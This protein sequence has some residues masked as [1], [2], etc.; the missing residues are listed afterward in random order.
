MTRPVILLLVLTTTSVPLLGQAQAPKDE[1]GAYLAPFDT[2]GNRIEL[3]VANSTGKTYENVEVRAI[4]TPAW[5]TIEP[6]TVILEEIAAEDEA[7]ASFTF[8]TD[9]SAPTQETYALTFDVYSGDELI[10]SKQIDISVELPKELVL[11]GNYPNPFNPSTT[12]GFVQPVDGDVELEIFDALGRRVEL[13][14]RNAS[15]RGQQTFRWNA[16]SRATGVYFYR[17]EL[18]TEGGDRQTKLGKMLFIK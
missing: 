3:A 16:A 9:D 17:L 4:D 1:Q 8:S 6:A 5:I 11:R 14:S 10:A 2:K 12:V 13:L 7:L 15:K 18:R